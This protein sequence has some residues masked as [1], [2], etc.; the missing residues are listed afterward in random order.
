MR[1]KTA[2]H[3]NEP[4]LGTVMTDDPSTL[5]D[6]RFVPFPASRLVYTRQP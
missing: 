1:T 4:A 5:L 6:S 3:Q 2:R